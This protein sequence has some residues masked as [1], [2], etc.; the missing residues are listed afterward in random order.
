MQDR[1]K[2]NFPLNKLISGLVYQNG[3]VP[4]TP[5]TG[6]ETHADKVRSGNLFIAVHGTVADGHDFVPQALDNGAAAVISNGRDLGDLPVP[7]IKVGN[8]RKAVSIVAAEYYGHPSKSLH[9]TGITGTNGKTTVATILK[10]I[11]TK[12]NYK[13]AQLGTLGVF[14]DGFPREKSLTTPDPISLHSL[15]ADLKAEG[16]THIVMEVSSHSLDQHRVADVAFNTAIYTNLTPEHLDYHESME[17]YFRAKARLFKS[18]PITGT[19]IVNMD[20]K[21]GIRFQKESTAPVITTALMNGTDVSFKEIESDLNGIR[22]L[23]K[24]GDLRIPVASSLIGTFNAENILSAAAG[25]ITLGISEKH[26][27]EGI[28]SCTAIEGRMER[29]QLANGG[30]VI[31]DYAHTP[32]A[33]EKVLST[34]KSSGDSGA[35][36]TVIFGCGGDRDQQKRPLMAAAAETYTDR[37]FITPDN[38]RTE[39][40]AKINAD[41]LKG[42]SSNCCTVFEDR[43]EALRTAFS[44]AGGNDVVIVL[45]KGREEYQEIAGEKVPYS[46]FEIIMEHSIED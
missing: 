9:I 23:I 18:L 40:I 28:N 19:S 45:G 6:I 12:A 7:Q 27:S 11:L 37:C 31:M 34:I 1:I 14:A 21:S 25:A 20:D 16:F 36:I 44:D 15:L 10:S 8:P 43:G 2:M 32:D 38:P 42:F 26:I 17:D 13:T 30:V 29:F 41:I 3:D 33:Y 39:S 35:R 5:I 22:G 46:D 4:P 24:A